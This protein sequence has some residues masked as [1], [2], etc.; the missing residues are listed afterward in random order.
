MMIEGDLDETCTVKTVTKISRDTYGRP[1]KTE[2][3]VTT[4]CKFIPATE[5][6]VIIGTKERYKIPLRII[7]PYGV[8]ITE[9]DQI[10]TTETGYAGT[11]DITSAIPIKGRYGIECGFFLCELERYD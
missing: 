11:Y 9:G 1:S 2:T 7:L 8:T 4:K 10:T 5:T 6:R 3:S